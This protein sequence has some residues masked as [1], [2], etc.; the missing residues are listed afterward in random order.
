MLPRPDRSRVLECS[1]R[2]SLL[3]KG[4]SFQGIFFSPSGSRFHVAAPAAQ[5]KETTFS[6]GRLAEDVA[7]T[8]D[9][10]SAP[11]AT[12]GYGLDDMSA[13]LSP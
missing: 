9:P 12:V 8:D 1:G 2:P 3:T 10:T 7:V 4:C 5:T 6:I 13:L 11:R